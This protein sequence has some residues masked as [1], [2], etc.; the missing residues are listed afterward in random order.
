MNNSLYILDDS[1]R[2][3][4]IE[5]SS[6]D[7]TNTFLKNYHPVDPKEMTLVSTDFQTAGRGQL[8]NHWESEQGKNLLFS[9]RIQ[10]TGIQARQQFLLSQAMSLAICRTLKEYTEG[11]TIKWPNDIYWHDRKICGFIVENFLTGHLIDTCIIGAGVN[12]NQTAFASDA[13]NP[14]SLKL[15]TGKETERI[16]ILARIVELFSSYYRQVCSGQ[17][18]EIIKEYRRSLYRNQGFHPYVDQDGEFE[19]EIHDIE[20]TGHLVLSDRQGKLR[21]YAFKEVKCLISESRHP[22]LIL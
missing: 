17:H 3:E 13:P 6:T 20:P 18:G 21:R 11:I 16:F 7:S 19:A 22:D 2:F 8:G 5:L 4:W 9:L 1:P 14:T 15:I 12:V 10:P